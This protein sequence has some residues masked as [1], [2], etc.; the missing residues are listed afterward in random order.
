[1]SDSLVIFCTLLACCALFGASVAAEYVRRIINRLRW[2]RMLAK[3]ATKDDPVV[4]AVIATSL[5]LCAY[6]STRG[7]RK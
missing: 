4:S 7:K 3:R 5:V 6:M 2:V 1:M